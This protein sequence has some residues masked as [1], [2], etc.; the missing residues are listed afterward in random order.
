MNKVSC[1]SMNISQCNAPICVLNVFVFVFYSGGDTYRIGFYILEDLHFR[2][3]FFE[4]EAIPSSV[5]AIKA[6]D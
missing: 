2:F 4:L 3:S 5:P 1:S 6:D